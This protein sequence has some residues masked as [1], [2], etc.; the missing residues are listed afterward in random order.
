MPKEKLVPHSLT[1]QPSLLDKVKESAKNK[2][3]G[4]VNREI[5]RLI[6]KALN[7]EKSI[8]K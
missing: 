7:D 1:I 8:N 4:I 3:E 2:S 6:N 5:R